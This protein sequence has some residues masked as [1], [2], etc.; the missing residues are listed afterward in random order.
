MCIAYILYV[1]PV[2]VGNTDSGLHSTKVVLHGGDVHIYDEADEKETRDTGTGGSGTQKEFNNPIYG[3]DQ[4]VVELE[5]E[6]ETTDEAR[7]KNNHNNQDQEPER[8]FEN[9]VYGDDDDVGNINSTITPVENYDQVGNVYHTLESEHER[10]DR[11]SEAAQPIIGSADASDSSKG[12]TKKPHH[13]YEDV[14]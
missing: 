7:S 6:Y 2:Y 3:D 10:M 9:P 12:Q 1:C 13:S 4:E 5:H 14:Q 8:K 11:Y